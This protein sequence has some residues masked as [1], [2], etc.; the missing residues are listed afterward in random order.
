MKISFFNWLHYYIK[1][2]FKNKWRA[3]LSIMGVSVS[4]TIM[5]TGNFTIDSYYSAQ[6]NKYKHYKEHNIIHNKLIWNDKDNNFANDS[7]KN[8]KNIWERITYSLN[9]TAILP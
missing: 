2:M 1:D 9:I 7:I 3:F 5:M 6:F 8:W 4:L